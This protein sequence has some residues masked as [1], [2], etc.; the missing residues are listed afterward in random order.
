MKHIK[1]LILLAIPL[2]LLGFTHSRISNDYDTTL[3]DALECKFSQCQAIAKSTGNQC[4]HCVSN[5][6]D[7]YCWQHD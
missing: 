4:K 2:L 5:K 6:G 3:K 1:I 7:L